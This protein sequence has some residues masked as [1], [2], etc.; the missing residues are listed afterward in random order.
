MKSTI[1]MKT[2]I[3]TPPP[4]V[5]LA[6]SLPRHLQ[7][8]ETTTTMLSLFR[9]LALALLTLSVAAPAHADLVYV[10]DSPETLVSVGETVQLNISLL[11]TP[12][13]IFWTRVYSAPA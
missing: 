12:G 7:E 10:F 4:A 11:E 8:R 3:G 5:V 9:K 1:K 6:P 2:K 13:S